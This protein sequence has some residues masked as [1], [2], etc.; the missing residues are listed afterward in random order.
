MEIPKTSDKGAWNWLLL[1]LLLIE[2]V[3]AWFAFSLNDLSRDIASW[4][5]SFWI[6]WGLGGL[7][8]AVVPL[9]LRH[10]AGGWLSALSGLV[11]LV[12]ACIPLLGEKPAA[13]A[14]L[15][16]MATSATL[17]F[18]FLYE[19]SYWEIDLN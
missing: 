11:L 5:T 2:R 1:G 19:Q 8:L 4:E 15:V 16:I 13:D 6:A 10:R 14:V 18:A 7:L 3:L 17:T 12:R 9:I